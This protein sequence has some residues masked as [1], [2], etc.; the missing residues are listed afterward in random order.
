M[1]RAEGRYASGIST[2]ISQ[3]PH[4]WRESVVHTSSYKIKKSRECKVQTK[5][6]L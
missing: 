2:G 1:L 5:L 6:A 3:L 4:D